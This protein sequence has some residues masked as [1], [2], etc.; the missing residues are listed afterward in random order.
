MREAK[1]VFWDEASMQHKFCIEAVDRMFR[2]VNDVPDL[3]FGGVVVCFC[4]DFRQTLPIVP[5]GLPASIIDAC[6]KKSYLWDLIRVLPLTINMRLQN[7]NLTDQGRRELADFAAKL[8]AVGVRTGPDE[9]IVWTDGRGT[10]NSIE[11]LIRLIYSPHL[12]RAD[13]PPGFWN[14][15]AILATT[16]VKVNEINNRIIRTMPRELKTIMSAEETVNNEDRVNIPIETLN[17]TE[18][19]HL[20]PHL[21]HLKHGCPVMLLRN[22]DPSKGLCNGTR[23]HVTNIGQRFLECVI[24]GGQYKGKI[25]MLPRIPM[26]SQDNNPRNPIRFI[27]RQFPVRLAFGMTIHKSQGQSL[28][29]VGANLKK[30][31]F[32]HGQLYVVFSRVTRQAGLHII[33]PDK[34]TALQESRIKNVV[35]RQVLL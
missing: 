3:P 16:N 28:A 32:A 4:G 31:C 25:H 11:G 22:L 2:D 9:R 19:S 7:P 29:N 15:R 24:V 27:R 14:D 5:R 8:L 26:Q 35:W 18:S 30:E 34:P 13:A 10:D 20:P 12:L 21:L 17:A 1:V 6:L 23:L 33:V